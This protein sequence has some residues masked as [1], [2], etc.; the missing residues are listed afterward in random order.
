M[1]IICI[2]FSKSRDLFDAKRMLAHARREPQA[3]ATEHLDRLGKALDQELDDALAEI[4][5]IADDSPIKT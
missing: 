3:V 5:K 4:K 2:E 1:C